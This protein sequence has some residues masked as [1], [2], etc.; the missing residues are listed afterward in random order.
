MNIQ[1]QINELQSQLDELKAQAAK[2]EEPEIDWSKMIGR[3][4]EVRNCIDK[5]WL[6]PRML[7]GYATGWDKPFTAD[8]FYAEAKLYQG[9]TRPNW[10]EWS[11]GECPVDDCVVV[12]FEMRSGEIDLCAIPLTIRWSHVGANGDILRYTIIEP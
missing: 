10:I 6:G 1:Q 7:E 4:V 5:D 12:L 9:P 8:G 2:C 11:G 3:L